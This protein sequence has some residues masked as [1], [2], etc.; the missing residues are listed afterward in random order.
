MS[1][2]SA[3]IDRPRPAAVAVG[4]LALLAFALRLPGLHQAL[5]GDELFTYDIVTRTGLGDLL[6][7]V[8]DTSITPPL[9][10]VLAYGSQ[11]LGNPPVSVRLPS[12][13][14]GAAVVPLVYLLGLRTVGRRA[15]VLAAGF[16]ALSPFLIFYGSE[17][18]AYATLAFLLLLGTLALVRA[19]SAGA[20]PWWWALFAAA[21]AASLY[22]HYTAAIYLAAQALWALVAYRERWRALL[23]ANGAVALAFL[24]WIPAYLDQR[25]NPGVE[26]VAGQFPSG[27]GPGVEAYANRVARLLGGSPFV[28]LHGPPGPAGARGDGVGGAGGGLAAAAAPRP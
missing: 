3:W 26:A 27:L 9:H 16:T 15:G 18:R 28:D 1:A 17:A 11:K 6:A 19:L 2:G 20:S 14:A 22:T 12:L 10:Y 13:L 7:Q 4:A 24:P 25:K 21:G 5:Y 23:A 8:R